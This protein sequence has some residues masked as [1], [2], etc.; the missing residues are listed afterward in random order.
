VTN[1][2]GDTDLDEL[3]DLGRYPLMSPGSAQWK[4]AVAHVRQ[5][6]SSI[7]CSVL[8]G[9]VQRHVVDR[10]REESSRLAPQ[11]YDTIETVN[12]Y[13]IAV[14][15]EMPDSH[16]ARITME[17]GN[18]FVARDLI[19]EDA[20]V[21]RL[22]INTYFQSFIANCFGLDEIHEL[23][24][25][26]AGLCVNVVAPG[27]EHP[28]HFDTNEFTVSLLTVA[29][30]AGGCFEFCPDIRTE[31]AEN[32]DEVKAVLTGGSHPGLRQLHLRPGDLQLFKGRYALHRVTTVE[33]TTPRQSAI[34]AY[35]AR[36]GVMG[37]V[38]RTRQ[39]FGRV[40]PAHHAGAGT[41]RV[42]Q[43]LD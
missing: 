36:P 8:S 40:L 26:L 41:G 3:V 7:G 33:G 37:S 38:E 34:F 24:D 30:D 35:T 9:F 27:R 11:A 23:A 15:A 5:E 32:L 17:R 25:P 42:D 2:K 43:L 6:L 31:T 19:P 39:L 20:L 14:D 28:W 29:P 16:P 12:A 13:N 22:Y 21:H 18:A 10:L 4:E 1:V